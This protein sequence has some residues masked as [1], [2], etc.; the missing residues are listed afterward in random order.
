[1]NIFILV[2]SSNNGKFTCDNSNFMHV[3]NISKKTLNINQIFLYDLKYEKKGKNKK[4][5]KTKKTLSK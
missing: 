1:L 2:M 3:F 4:T 5:K